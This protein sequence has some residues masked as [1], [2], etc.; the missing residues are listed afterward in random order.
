MEAFR[1]ANEA[2]KVTKKADKLREALRL[3]ND[4]MNSGCDPSLY[5]GVETGQAIIKALANRIQSLTATASRPPPTTAAPVD[6]VD[7]VDPADPVVAG[8]LRCTTP[9][10]GVWFDGLKTTLDRPTGGE[11]GAPP[12]LS[13]WNYP[14]NPEWVTGVDFARTKGADEAVRL[15]KTSVVSQFL[16]PQLFPP[17]IAQRAF[18]L[19]GVPG[20]GKTRLATAVV[21]ATTGVMRTKK[22][23]A[24]LRA[25]QEIQGFADAFWPNTTIPRMIFYNVSVTD[26]ASPYVGE[27]ARRLSRWFELAAATSPSVIFFDEADAYLDPSV[28]TNAGPIAVFKQMMGGMGKQRVTV[29]LATNYPSRIESAV[30]S[31]VAGG[32]IEVPLPNMEG[33]KEIVNQLLTEMQDSEPEGLEDIPH[34]PLKDFFTNGGATQEGIKEEIVEWVAKAT[35][36]NIAQARLWSARDLASLVRRAVLINREKV[37]Q[38]CLLNCRDS[39]SAACQ[40]FDT[41]ENI[42]VAVP[43]NTPGCVPA[44]TL[45]ERGEGG[46]ILPLPLTLQEF[47]TA[48]AFSQPSVTRGALRSQ[49]DFNASRGQFGDPTTQPWVRFVY[50]D[51]CPE[52][53]CGANKTVPAN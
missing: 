23:E 46:L 29:I 35:A 40:F 42:W 10:G 43:G 9:K 21:N 11:V 50:G 24:A 4:M 44:S 16:M 7:P 32:A 52:E 15:L 12:C 14:G 41:S 13:P 1:G 25:K 33:R 45:A 26:I 18:L 36:P 38:G 28:Q 8:A 19:Y 22:G 5:G 47:K 34:V 39:P 17:A 20:T 30:L 37:A 53:G 6:P 2:A 49:M 3:L 51:T 27:P 31:R 48:L